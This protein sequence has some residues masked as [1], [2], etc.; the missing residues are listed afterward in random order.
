MSYFLKNALVDFFPPCGEVPG[1]EAT[2]LD[3]FLVRYRREV[4]PMMRFGIHLAVVL[5]TLGPLFTVGRP[6]LAP[7]LSKELRDRHAGRIS[8][9]PVYLVRQAMMLL[10]TVGG[11]CWGAHPRVRE[12]I[13]VRLY[14]PDP[15]TFRT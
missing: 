11:L 14:G 1:I 4:A 7:W 13:G 5:Y 8:K 6:V 12:A 15:G 3:E 9:S 2:D 10:K